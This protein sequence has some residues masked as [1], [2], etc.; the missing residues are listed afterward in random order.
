MLAEQN[1]VAAL[2]DY[3]TPGGRDI[4][5]MLR[6]VDATLQ[7]IALTDEAGVQSLSGN[8]NVYDFVPKPTSASDLAKLIIHAAEH[9]KLL[10]R[11]QDTESMLA[12]S[13]EQL[14]TS[15]RSLQDAQERLT[16]TSTAALMGQLAEGLRHELGNA[17]TVIRLNMSLIVYHRDDPT[18]FMRHMD[19]LEQGVRSIERIAVALRDFP[20]VQRESSEQL[21]LAY[22]VR[23]AAEQAQQLYE[24]S[25]NTIRLDLL[26]GAPTR[27]SFFQ[28]VRAFG[29]LIENAAEASVQ[30]NVP[31]ALIS[32]ALQSDG[33]RWKV[34]IRDNGAGLTVEALAHAIEP[35]YTTKVDRGFMR[36]LGLG[37]F[38]A[39][40]ILERHGGQMRLSNLPEGGTLVEVWLPK[41]AEPPKS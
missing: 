14:S 32:I 22:I 41:D 2:A 28:L 37:L 4:I 10:R 21:D 18:R 36:G 40:T 13:S 39:D 19:S 15:L 27:G 30:S 8:E 20:S 25:A 12:R 17:L 23:H 34:T 6:G 33:N 35:G 26:P 38:V 16:R 31:G 29:A 7:C 1:V 24:L 11:R 3:T 9:T 5:G